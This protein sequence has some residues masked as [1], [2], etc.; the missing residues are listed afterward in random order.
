M[1]K[2]S[3]KAFM[4]ANRELCVDVTTHLLGDKRM[5]VN[6]PYYGI[7]R[8][9]EASEENG[10]REDQMDFT[11]LGKCNSHRNPH[12]Y[13]GEL[14]TITL[15]ADGSLRPNFRPIPEWAR[16]NLGR[17]AMHVY[18]ELN[19]ALSHIEKKRRVA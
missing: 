2:I 13:V 19:Y 8:R 18:A 7:L 10:W 12:L 6:K 17:Y 4:N 11:Q 15:Q 1:K 3:Y 5:R 14:I 16:E 9:L